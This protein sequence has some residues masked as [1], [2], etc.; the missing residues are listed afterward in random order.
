[1]P[2][3]TI[4]QM[5]TQLIHVQQELKRVSAELAHAHSSTAALAANQ[6]AE[7]HSLTAKLQAAQAAQAAPQPVSAKQPPQDSPDDVYS[8]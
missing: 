8:G 1:M 3:L 5:E 6:K 7:I 2:D 4:A